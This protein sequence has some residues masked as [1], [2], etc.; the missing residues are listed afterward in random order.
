[1]YLN[2]LKKDLKRKKTMNVIL[3]VFMIIAVMFVSSSANTLISVITALDGYLDMAGAKDYFAAT[4]GTT[5]SESIEN[6]LKSSEYVKSYQAENILYL[7][8]EAAEYKGE[9][10]NF[11]S[12]GV[13]NSIDNLAIKIYDGNQNEIS[14]ISDGEIYIAAAFFKEHQ[15]TEGSTIK[16]KVGN[17][18]QEFTVRGRLMDAILGSSMMSAPRFVISQNDFDKYK[19]NLSETYDSCIGKL[20]CIETDHIS[21]IEA[22]IS[23]NEGVAFNATRDTIK[24]TYIMDMINAGLFLV[25]SIC[26]IVISLVLLKFTVSFTI[27]EEYREIGVM[28]AIGIRN[29]KIRML[30]LVKYFTMAITATVIG[31]FGGLPFGKM[32]ISQASETIIINSESNYL[33][34]VI[35]SLAVVMLILLFCWIS[36]AKVK[37]FTPVDAIRNGENGKR[38]KKKGFIRLSKTHGKP[39]FFMALNDVLSGFRHFAV[40]TVTFTVGILIITIILNTMTTLTSDKLITWISMA[41]CDVTVEDTSALEKYYTSDGQEKREKYLKEMEKTLADN[42]IPAQCFAETVFKLKIENGSHKCKSLSFH[43]I[44]VTTDQY[45]Y[46]EG[47]APQNENEI[48]ITHVIA[49]RL[50]AGVGDK[51][52]VETTN[53]S[54]EF[55]ITAI[56]QSMN[57]FGEGIRFSEKYRMDYSKAMGFF[58]YQIRYTDHPSESEK[59]T[60]LEKIKELYP[61]DT[62]R[63]SGEYVDYCIGGAAGYMSDSKDFIVLVIMMI[64]ILVVILMEKSFMTKER[65]EIAL[66]KAMGFKNISVVIWQTARIAIVMLMSVLLAVIFA[67]PAAQL[68]VGGIFKTMGAYNISFAIDYVQTYLTYPLIVFAATV[69]AAFVSA[70]SVKGIQSS[71]V[72]N[73]E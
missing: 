73:I 37:K 29:A 4:V 3:L 18:T 27:S 54:S 47:T 63:T 72:N 35:C 2:I 31:F 26:L 5:G 49:D 53:G 67:E 1:M 65:S 42:G 8:E 56:Y 59:E 9:K 64:N 21:E 69:M 50:S 23:D 40:M 19:E 43:G 55:I 71:E 60:R 48:A 33:I 41:E 11:P 6:S 46:I 51:V 30:Y 24:L 58:A 36:T 14:D 39:I 34:N 68:A 66:L 17:I 10:I 52:T 22:L 32:M 62:V 25:V 44:G 28:K 7:Q 12:L 16:I 38:Y 61:E 15:I 57:N 45:P 13:L 70:W 20:L